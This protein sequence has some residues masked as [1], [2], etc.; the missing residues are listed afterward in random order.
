[1]DLRLRIGGHHPHLA[2]DGRRHSNAHRL[3]NRLREDFRRVVIRMKKDDAKSLV[4]THGL[5]PV[6]QLTFP[7]KLKCVKYVAGQH[8]LVSVD[9]DGNVCLLHEDGRVWS[10]M[11]LLWPI[12]GLLYAAGVH[13]YVAWNQQGL[14]L[15]DKTLALVSQIP[16]KEEVLCCVYDPVN[17]LVLSGS[18]GGISIWSFSHN[19]HRLVWQQ[20]LSQAMKD[21]DKVQVIALDTESQ[22]PHTCLAACG[23]N[24]WEFN[25]MD[26]SLVR[27]RKNLHFRIITSLVYSENLQL[28]ISGS[29]DFTIK[30]WGGDGQ[31]IAAF[32]GHTGAI[33]ALSLSTSRMTLSSGSEDKTIRMWDLNTQE[34]T[35]ELELS[36]SP[37]GIE[38]FGDKAE[39]VL[40][41]S[42]FDIHIWQL[43]QLYKLHCLLG[44]NV[45]DI[46]VIGGHIPARALCVC[47]DGTLRLISTVTGDPI[48]TL[49]LETYDSLLVADYCIYRETVCVLLKDGQLLKANALVNPMRVLSKVNVGNGHSLPLCF[50]L[51]SNIMDTEVAISEWRQVVKQQ[52]DKES[53]GTDKSM[54]NSFF[55]IIGS[56]D[57]I[58]RVCDW[59]SFKPLCQTKAH[60]PSQVTSIICDP[61]NNYIISAGS[62]LAVK[63]W[64]F[65]AHTEQSLSLCMSFFCTQPVGRMCSF[66][67][68]LFVAF[69]D[70]SNASYS[71]VQYC[72]RTEARKDHR[73]SDD[74]QDQITG[75]CCCPALRLLATCGSDGRIRLWNYQNQLIRTLCLNSTPESL[76]FI[77][78]CGDLLVGMRSH[79]YR[80]HLAKLLP[81]SYQVKILCMAACSKLTDSPDPAHDGLQISLATGDDKKLTQTRRDL[82][83]DKGVTWKTGQQEQEYIML[84]SRDQELH[85]IR[86]GKLK[87]HKK[88]KSN[89]NTRRE[90]MEQYLQ[91]VYRQK[92]H[93][94]IPEDD[95]VNEPPPTRPADDV[96]NSQGES[97]R[98]FFDSIMGFPFHSLPRP[99]QASLLSIGSIP[100][101]ALLQLLWPMERPQEIRP[102][103]TAERP[104]FKY[105]PK[106]EEEKEVV[107]VKVEEVI[108]EPEE[109][110]DIPAILQKFTAN[111]EELSPPVSDLLPLP[112]PPSVQRHEEQRASLPQPLRQVPASVQPNPQDSPASPVPNMTPKASASSLGTDV[113]EEEWPSETPDVV[114]KI[115]PF[116]LQF[117]DTS[118]FP[119]IFSDMQVEHSEFLAQLLHGVVHM[120]MPVRI[121][122]LH[123]LWLLYQQGHLKDPEGT[124]QTLLQVVISGS[125]INMKVG[126][127]LNFLWFC[128]HFLIQLSGGRRDVVLE[129]LVTCVQI[130]PSYRGRFLSLFKDIGVEDPHGFIGRQVTTWDSWEHAQG[131]RE[132]LRRTCED[133]LDRWTRRLMEYLHAAMTQNM[134]QHKS[135]KNRGKAPRALSSQEH[136]ASQ[137][138][139]ESFNV[140]PSDVLNFYCELQMKREIQTVRDANPAYESTV[141]ALPPVYRKRA[142][143]RL[144]ESSVYLQHRDRKGV[145]LPPIL[146]RHLSGFIPFIN[147]PL[148]RISI[149]PF[150]PTLESRDSSHLTGSL[151]QEAHQYFIL[152]QSYLD[153]YY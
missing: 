73:P 15:L 143:L 24:V 26:G 41:Y 110:S 56:D 109:S 35:E 101:S 136:T 108:E 74:H 91:L 28:L 114:P 43:Q 36:G 52:G 67:S 55:P 6:R 85:L 98:G 83:T 9:F 39:Q 34:Q 27:V 106:M 20:S 130:H 59:Y 111:M 23:T 53:P 25:L 7:A 48:S 102:Q 37:I 113:E 45:K 137:H 13:I 96:P 121:E 132:S 150:T 84:S 47:T 5:Q 88:L 46:K 14:L 149:N 104:F 97:S 22:N 90:A 141:L 144:G 100:N 64:R 11:K 49:Y 77:G 17:N 105:I 4:L 138:H 40:C 63:V 66:K 147:L 119:R 86:E 33:T 69:H 60:S 153:S 124:F 61:K 148:K 51:Y 142:L 125:G 116:I 129:L 3:W 95:Y 79:L 122:L 72:L 115:P 89:T 10:K 75:L 31:L 146:H 8:C 145:S 123:A 18:I 152:Q 135:H 118:W 140:T 151:T 16:V 71:L 65:F 38:A 99:L 2:T 127:D 21:Q 80:I 32:I 139:L 50:T 57:G 128:L 78:D 30:V 92:P 29:R 103:K 94:T 1:M 68:Q 93:I 117:Q 134:N 107:V 62:D 131:D 19:G 54:K 58:L 81:N 87:P 126:E 42:S 120:E 76:A 44:T 70:T 112:S 133:W 82:H 12:T